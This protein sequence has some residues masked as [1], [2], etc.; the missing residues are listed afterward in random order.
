MFGLRG[1]KALMAVCR[2]KHPVSLMSQQRE[3]DLPVGRE[4]VNDQNRRHELLEKVRHGARTGCLAGSTVSFAGPVG[5]TP[6]IS[7]I[8]ERSRPILLRTILS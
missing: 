5:T 7:S 2:L 6:N 8:I 4:V 3:Q 1:D